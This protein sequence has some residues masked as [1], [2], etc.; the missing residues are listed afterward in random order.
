VKSGNLWDVGSLAREYFQVGYT[1]PSV[2]YHYHYYYYYSP[3]FFIVFLI[4]LCRI[5]GRR[6]TQAANHVEP[7]V[8]ADNR[9][10]Q[11]SVNIVVHSDNAAS[12]DSHNYGAIQ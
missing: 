7:V 9:A 1:L 8:V 3:V 6:Q 12:T 10:S 5:I 4:S 2:P 11:A